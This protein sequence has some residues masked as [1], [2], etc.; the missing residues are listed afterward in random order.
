MSNATQCWEDVS[1]IEHDKY[2]E[3]IEPLVILLYYNISYL[4]SL[5]YLFYIF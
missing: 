3:N 5:V 1:K 4:S 2:K